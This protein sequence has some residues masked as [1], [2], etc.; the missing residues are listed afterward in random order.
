[1]AV[2]VPATTAAVTEAELAA[3]V[4]AAAGETTATTTSAATA[5]ASEAMQAVTAFQSF[6]TEAALF[7][8]QCGS[9]I[10]AITHWWI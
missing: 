3:A 1:M 2:T 4:T 7:S 6:T 10:S 8:H 5:I 9:D